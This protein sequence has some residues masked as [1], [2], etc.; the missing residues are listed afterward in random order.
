MVCFYL[1]GH[2]ADTRL[3]RVLALLLLLGGSGRSTSLAAIGLGERL[4]LPMTMEKKISRSM[5]VFAF[6]GSVHF[7]MSRVPSTLVDDGCRRSGCSH[8]RPLTELL[9]IAPLSE[10]PAVR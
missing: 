4:L 8:R 10:N 7:R 2:L 6:A 1:D 3:M 5:E 9:F